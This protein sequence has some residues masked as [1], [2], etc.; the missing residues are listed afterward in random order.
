M[1]MFV[2]RD[3][4]SYQNFAIVF[5]E[6]F[7]TYERQLLGALLFWVPRSIWPNKPIGSGAFVDN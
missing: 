3:F 7:I 5:F 4:D 1:N 6:D 2:A